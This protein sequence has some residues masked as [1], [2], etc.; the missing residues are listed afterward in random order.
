[1]RRE[2]YDRSFASPADYDDG[3]VESDMARMEREAAIQANIDRKIAREQSAAAKATEVKPAEVKPAATTHKPRSKGTYVLHKVPIT[4]HKTAPGEAGSDRFWR[5]SDAER[6]SMLKIMDE[7]GFTEDDYDDDPFKYEISERTMARPSKAD[8]EAISDFIE[9]TAHYDVNMRDT[10][11][12]D[13]GRYL[14]INYYGNGVPNRNDGRWND[15][16]DKSNQPYAPD[17]TM[18]VYESVPRFGMH[19]FWRVDEAKSKFTISFIPRDK[20]EIVHTLTADECAKYVDKR[21]SMA[22]TKQVDAGILPKNVSNLF[23]M[24]DQMDSKNS[25]PGDDQRSI[26]D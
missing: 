8:F 21:N 4:L 18:I 11:M 25:Q 9:Q 26:V 19:E 20:Y 1:M 22:Y 14:K 10:S 15:P 23:A 16:Y 6:D 13:T 17:D 2:G 3:F 7:Y 12:V 24:R 5:C